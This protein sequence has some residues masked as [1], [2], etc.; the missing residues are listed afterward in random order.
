MLLCHRCHDITKHESTQLRS[1]G[2]CEGCGRKKD[3]LEC[4]NPQC[5]APPKP[6]RIRK[7]YEFKIHDNL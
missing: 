7:R 2:P 3:C 6:K 1:Y 5:L 4:R